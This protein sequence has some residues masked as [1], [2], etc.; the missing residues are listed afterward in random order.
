MAKFI[1]VTFL[2]REG[3][4][5]EKAAPL[6]VNIDH[7]ITFCPDDDQKSHLTLIEYDFALVV[8]ESPEE[9][10]ALINSKE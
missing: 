6:Y 5:S 8:K 10:L 7:V 1:K 2:R 9:I 4:P 3:S